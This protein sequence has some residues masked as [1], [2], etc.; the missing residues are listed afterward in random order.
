MLG[1]TKTGHPKRFS[2]LGAK[3]KD[4]IGPQEDSRASHFEEIRR[5]V[6][7]TATGDATEGPKTVRSPGRS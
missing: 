4:R 1:T 6:H 2:A 5:A 3:Q 7:S